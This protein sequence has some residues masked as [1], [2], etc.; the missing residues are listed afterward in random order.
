MARSYS[1]TANPLAAIENI[2][3]VL[4]VVC[5]NVFVSMVPL[6]NKIDIINIMLMQI[7]FNLIYSI[8]NVSKSN[9]IILDKIF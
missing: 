3:L 7:N 4:L 6:F 8:I 5:K 2:K 9:Q 1:L